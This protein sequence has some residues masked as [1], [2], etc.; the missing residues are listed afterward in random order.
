[1]FMGK[2][3]SGESIKLDKIPALVDPSGEV[4]N[5]LIKDYDAVLNFMNVEKRK[6]K[7]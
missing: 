4:S 7:L 5:F 2:Q 3:K 1:M 6:K